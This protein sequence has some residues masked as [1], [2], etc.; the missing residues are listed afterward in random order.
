MYKYYGLE[1]FTNLI[2]YLP[3][4]KTLP[5]TKGQLKQA[6]ADHISFAVCELQDV[7]RKI[8]AQKTNN[9]K[10]TF[11]LDYVIVLCETYRS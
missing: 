5:F 3:R 9:K 1:C 6:E 7:E 2:E 10:R 4:G 11:C 8:R